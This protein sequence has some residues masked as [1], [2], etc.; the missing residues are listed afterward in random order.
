VLLFVCLLISVTDCSDCGDGLLHSSIIIGIVVWLLLLT[1]FIIIILIILVC[2][3]SSVHHTSGGRG[4]ADGETAGD[5]VAPVSAPVWTSTAGTRQRDARVTRRI[6]STRSFYA[7]PWMNALA[8]NVWKDY[9]VET[10][11]ET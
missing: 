1:I 11:E 6:S 10:I 8:E 3:S 9:P 7:E 2:T 4:R 5:T